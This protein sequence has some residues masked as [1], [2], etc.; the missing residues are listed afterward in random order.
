MVANVICTNT[1]GNGCSA[2]VKFYKALL[3]DI[4]YVRVIRESGSIRRK[5][6]VSTSTG[7]HK[8]IDT[9]FLQ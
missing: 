6:I 7:D 2:F 3:Y 9:V 4:R 1:N 8:R 5:F